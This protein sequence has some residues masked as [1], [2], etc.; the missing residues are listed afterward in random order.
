MMFCQGYSSEAKH[1]LGKHKVIMSSIH[2]TKKIKI[3]Q[4]K[5]MIFLC[6]ASAEFFCYMET[7][8]ILVSEVL[9]FA[10]FFFAITKHFTHMNGR[11]ILGFR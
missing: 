10:P 8:D 9:S 11:V 7:R 4:N 1:L 3:K 2:G 5:T 6:V